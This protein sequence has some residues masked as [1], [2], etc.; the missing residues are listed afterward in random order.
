MEFKAKIVTCPNGHYYDSAKHSVCPICSGSQQMPETSVPDGMQSGGYA[1]MQE[2]M[3][4]GMDIPASG[5]PVSDAPYTPFGVPT[6]GPEGLGED[7][8]RE[9]V[10]GWLVC[11]EGP[12]YGADFRIH[13]GYNYIGRDIGDIQL[14]NDNRISRQKHSMI[15]FDN[16]SLLYFFGPMEGRSLVSVNGAPVLNAQQIH[17]Y[18]VLGIGSSKFLF[19]GLCGDK[20]QWKKEDEK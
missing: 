4:P 9:P 16:D 18:D 11:I 2:T 19:M 17:S 3:A 7:G 14:H 8:S 10:V 12:Q 20:F 15:A 6:V 1:E 13:S 5:A